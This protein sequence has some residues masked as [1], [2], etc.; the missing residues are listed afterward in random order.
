MAH[1]SSFDEGKMQLINDSITRERITCELPQPPLSPALL[2]PNT[3]PPKPIVER[4]IEK[5]SILGF[6]S[7]VTFCMKNVPNTNAIIN[8]GSEIQ[9][10]VPR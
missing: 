10:S 5:I 4:M 3:I 7:F 6:V 2:K 8:N 1:P 9:K